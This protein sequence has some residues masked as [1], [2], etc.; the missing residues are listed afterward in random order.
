MSKR[1]KIGQK[2]D[3]IS[4]Q[5]QIVAFVHVIHIGMISKRSATRRN[6][7]RESRASNRMIIII[8]KW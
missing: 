3:Q 2:E 6:Q 1:P 4:I 5:I 8:I 7:P